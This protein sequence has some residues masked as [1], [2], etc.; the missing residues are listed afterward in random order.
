MEYYHRFSKENSKLTAAQLELQK[1]FVKN[2]Q[3]LEL[4]ENVMELKE[5]VVTLAERKINL[6][7]RIKVIFDGQ[8]ENP[9]NSE[10]MDYIRDLFELVKEFIKPDGEVLE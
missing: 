7:K 5:R 4:E 10:K 2:M 6:N 9:G 3:Q 8:R 1:H